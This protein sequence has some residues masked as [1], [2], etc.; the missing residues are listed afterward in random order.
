[1]SDYT[2]P[3]EI[4]ID[5]GYAIVADIK[6]IIDGRNYTLGFSPEGREA[7]KETDGKMFTELFGWLSPEPVVIA[8][9]YIPDR[10]PT[11]S[12]EA[13]DTLTVEGHGTFTVTPWERY[14]TTNYTV[15]VG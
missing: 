8:A 4:L 10:R 12:V 13:G 3:S 9:H 6:V 2:I 1:M 14:L 15:T 7:R 11:V 5:K